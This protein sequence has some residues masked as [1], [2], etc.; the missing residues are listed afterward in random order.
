MSS[1]ANALSQ[2]MRL[3]Q[4]GQ[5]SEAEKEFLR[6]LALDKENSLAH[7]AL[8]IT[9]YQLDRLADAERY[10]ADAI[11]L[12]PDFLPAHNNLALVYKAM[13]HADRAMTVLRRALTIEPRYVDANYN[14]ALIQ[15]ES[16]ERHSAIASYRQVL[17]L[18]P[19]FLR[20]HTNLGLL[21]RADGDNL[22]ALGHLNIVATQTPQDVCA[23]VNLALVHTDL[24]H[25]AD[26]I[27]AG[28]RA[29]Q[30]APENFSA[31]EALG[32]AQRLGGDASSAVLSLQQAYQLNPASV[33]LQYEL[34]LSQDAAG[35]TEAARNTLN[36]VARLRPDWLKVLFTRD[37]ALP[38]LYVN[39]QHI[40]DSNAA[41]VAG[42]ENIEARLLG[43]SS[44]SVQQGVEAISGYAPFYLHYQGLDNTKLQRRFGRIVETVA[45]RAWPQFVEPATWKPLAHGGRLRV[46]FISAYLRHH[47]VGHFFGNWICQLNA[48]KFES[49]VWYTGEA[50][51]AVTEKIRARAAHFSHMVS[52]IAALGPAI[53]ASQLDV[54]IYLDVGMHPHSQVLAALH[55]AP[56]QC[57]TFGHPVTTGIDSIKYFLSADAAEPENAQQHYSEQ[58]I[59]LPQFAIS[60]P[61]PDTSRQRM[62]SAL[63][64]SRRPLIL[65]AQPL[66]KILPHFDRL[67]ARIVRE[68]P[69]C[70]LAFFQS[71]W[72][73]V[74]D[75][76]ISRIS[77]VL[78]DAG[79][80]PSRTLQMLPIMPYEEYL[81]TLAA[82]DVVLDTSGFS[83]GNSS[84]DAIAV[85]ASIVTPR[86]SMLRS[87]Q[88]AAML[89]IV[90]L[91]EFASAT[92]DDYVTNA[93][94]LASSKD[95]RRE[96]RER[97]IAGSTAL[98]N[99]DNCVRALERAFESASSSIGA[100]FRPTML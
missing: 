18:N 48:E 81:F 13:G 90:G 52:D 94:S 43:D 16:G 85:G 17:A 49:F 11:S 57:A 5:L 72:P 8:G 30:L 54:L 88:T 50:R 22:A 97:M 55:L 61:R 59:R 2:G 6:V 39:D 42:L 64:T 14:L 60:Y 77:A 87:R 47:S 93:I 62:P 12:N 20:A 92:E 70:R 79:V 96:M 46:G 40:A 95:Q 15:E 99:D 91:S 4:A 34:G 71:M 29:T 27:S 98:F 44:W 78:R 68:L 74:N 75:A 32:N 28:A 100:A 23:L 69:G 24:A 45:R 73:R 33:E 7:F 19:N 35:D 51:D 89:D 56:I 58:L 53:H 3:L 36:V 37:L 38:P 84:F 10:L 63:D 1:N 26:A 86:G 76:F 31:W 67:A 83:G 21:L 66:F 80:E 41:W 25:Y 9:C 82:A 65:C